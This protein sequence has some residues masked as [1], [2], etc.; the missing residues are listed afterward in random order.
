MTNTIY[1]LPFAH[2]GV[3]APLFVDAW[4]DEPYMEA[5]LD[6]KQPGRIFVDDP[7][8]PTAALMCRTY[9][10]Y[11][12]G[13][14]EPTLRRFMADAPAEVGVFQ[15]YY[16][17]TPLSK[18]WE[19]ALLDDYAGK[20][21]S[22][23][24]HNFRWVGAPLIDWRAELPDGARIVPIDRALA[25]R[26]DRE[27]HE[28]I[29]LLWSGYDAYI[30]GGFGFCLLMGDDLGSMAST[31]GVGRKL[32]NLG[33]RTGEKFRQ[34][35][36]A[37][38]ACSALIEDVLRRGLLPSWDTDGPNEPSKALAQSLGFVDGQPFAQIS[39]PG[40]TPLPL[41]EGRWQSE[42]LADAVVAWR[43]T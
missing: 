1:E 23:Y 11:L 12:A 28:T 7:Q 37:K 25:E 22:I 2:F 16:G 43:A 32:A 18:A 6:G 15:H 34:Q 5:V 42:V 19:Q 14:V 29:G 3:A 33:V 26:I 36:L 13:A 41:S 39:T 17:C 38:L 27:W 10:Y 21:I 8:Q 4:F 30:S 31:D 20:L 9:E 35:G 40:Y 24:R